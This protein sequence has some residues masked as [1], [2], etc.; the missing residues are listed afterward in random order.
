MIC[1]RSGP[2]SRSS[3]DPTLALRMG[4]ELG[5]E[6]ARLLDEAR[7]VFAASVVGTDLKRLD[8]TASP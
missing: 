2:G 3:I 7:S 1:S 6:D 5:A 4:N 8:R